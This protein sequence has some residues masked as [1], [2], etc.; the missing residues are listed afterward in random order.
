MQD[1]VPGLIETIRVREG[2][3]PFLPRHL[4][5]LKR[6]LAALGLP[7]PGRDVEAL[8][9]P[10][11]DVGEAVVRVEV[12]NGSA[13]V[14]V[15][16]VPSEALPVVRIATV[17]HQPYPHKVTARDAFDA[18][19]REVPGDGALLLTAAGEVAEGTIWSVFWWEGHRLRTPELGLGILD[20]IGRRRV[21]ELVEEV[22]EG[23][24]AVP[25]LRERSLFLVN[26]VRGVVP[27]AALDG[28][29]VPQDQRTHAIA[30]EFWP[31]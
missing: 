12:R 14:T 31:R 23:R 11:A 19:A 24:F 1:A 26:A 15:R 29:E 25:A 17:R 8:V 13:S 10:F 7:T 6:S 2:K 27:C 16:E 5:R 20:G 21:L 18:A 3:L 4:A 22:E 9:R 28:R 30:R